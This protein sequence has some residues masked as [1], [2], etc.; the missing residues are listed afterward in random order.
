MFNKFLKT[1]TAVDVTFLPKNSVIEMLPS[2]ILTITLSFQQKAP[3]WDPEYKQ[4]AVQH[5]LHLCFHSE[6]IL[7]I[8][9]LSP[10]SNRWNETS[11]AISFMSL[12]TVLSG[13]STISTFLA[14]SSHSISWLMALAAGRIRSAPTV[15]GFCVRAIWYSHKGHL[16]SLVF[17]LKCSWLV[18]LCSTEKLFFI[19]YIWKAWWPWCSFFFSFWQRQNPLCL[20]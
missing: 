10:P 4:A 18:F 3:H 7:N 8:S 5:Q 9:W 17:L 6:T 14:A 20:N 11:R 1:F 2:G 13:N 12:A 15:C 19:I 16:H